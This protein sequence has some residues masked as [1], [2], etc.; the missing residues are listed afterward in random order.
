META[1]PRLSAR[2]AW[3]GFGAKSAKK[4]ELTTAMPREEPKTLAGLQYACGA[5]GALGRD[6]SEGECFIGGDDQ[7]AAES[8]Q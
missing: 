2:A 7:A 5:S 8:G 1:R 4:I 3:C 6:V